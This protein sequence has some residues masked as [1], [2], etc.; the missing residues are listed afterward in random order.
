MHSLK[1][2]RERRKTSILKPPA[3][4]CLKNSPSINITRGCFHSCVYCYARGFMD[5]PPRGEVHLYENLPEKL[6]R[7]LKRKRRL[8]AWI[9]FSTASDAFQAVDE[10]LEVTYHVMKILLERGIGVSFLTKGLIPYEFMRLFKRYQNLIKARIGI[11]S[12][13]CGYAE[14]FEPFSASPIKRLS[15]IE[16]LLKAGID[17]A[18]RIDPIVPKITDSEESLERLIRALKV[19]GVKKVSVSALVMRPSLMEQFLSELPFRLA[20]EILTYYNGQSWQRVITSSKT[21]LLPRSMRIACYR[22]VRDLANQYGMECSVCGCKNPDLPWE[23]CNPWI[24][25]RESE[26]KS[27]QMGLFARPI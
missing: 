26:H 20:K 19:A 24:D 17:T 2:I 6:E 5:S 1:I 12:I 7:E 18:V 21:R 15:L 22:R 8:P 4:G 27:G 9:S 10:I 16:G 23:S 3:F 25:E 14:L 13:S 11:V